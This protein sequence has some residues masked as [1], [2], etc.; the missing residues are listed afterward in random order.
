MVIEMEICGSSNQDRS[1][2]ES[3][4][5]KSGQNDRELDPSS[6]LVKH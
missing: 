5:I 3:P 6:Y 4:K 1:L 2:F